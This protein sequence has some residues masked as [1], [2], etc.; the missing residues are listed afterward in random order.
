M[1]KETFSDVDHAI[2]K[3]LWKWARRATPH[4][5]KMWVKASIGLTT[6]GVTGRLG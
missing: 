1:A 4:K 5:P 6:M 2:W 3:K